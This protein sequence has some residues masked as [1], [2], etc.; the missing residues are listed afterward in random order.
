MR[1]V[2]QGRALEDALRRRPFRRT[3]LRVGT[4]AMKDVTIHAT[5]RLRRPWRLLGQQQTHGPQRHHPRR[6]PRRSTIP[7]RLC[8]ARRTSL[9]QPL[10]DRTLLSRLLSRTSTPRASNSKRYPVAPTCYASCFW[11]TSSFPIP[12]SEAVPNKRIM[13]D[14]QTTFGRI[15][16]TLYTRTTCFLQALRGSFRLSPP[17]RARGRP[18]KPPPQ[19]DLPPGFATS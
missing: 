13:H 8:Q 16:S 10:G 4:S 11:P 5:K 2:A 6:F 18:R 14:L 19:G 9:L 3:T 15:H 1:H 12:S 17:A 7:P